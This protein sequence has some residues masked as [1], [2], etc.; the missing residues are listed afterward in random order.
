MIPI[1]TTSS[2]SIQQELTS[3][4]MSTLHQSITNIRYINCSLAKI[5]LISKQSNSFLIEYKLN[6][7]IFISSNIE[8]Y[9]QELFSIS[10]QWIISNCTFNCSIL[11][12]SNEKLQTTSNEICIPSKTLTFGIYELKLM[13]TVNTSSSILTS[14]ESI[15]IKIIQSNK[16]IVN[17]IEFGVSKI[18]IGI[19]EQFLLEPGK[20]S[21]H[22]DGTKI[23]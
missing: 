11:N 17:Q 1:Q 23:N 12:L 2:N 21:F 16:I 13:M 15:F 7:D 22:D 18:S 5:E 4:K 9:C 19:N 3:T 8:F 6:E 10:F 14:F 20:Y